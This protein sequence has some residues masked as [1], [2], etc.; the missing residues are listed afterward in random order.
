MGTG[1][2]GRSE[3]EAA[4]A[5][6]EEPDHEGLPKSRSNEGSEWTSDMVT[7]REDHVG[8]R[9]AAQVKGQS[10]IGLCLGVAW[11]QTTGVRLWG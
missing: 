5:G 2:A 6:R 7:G 11:W 4:A 8:G 10:V 1:D 3:E 9:A